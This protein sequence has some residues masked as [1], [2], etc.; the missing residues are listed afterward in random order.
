MSEG[1]E[2]R[3]AGEEAL[4]GEGTVLVLLHGRGADETDLLGLSRHLPATWTVVAP[5]APFSATPWGY[6]PGW[7]WYRY[8]GEDRPEPE[9]YEQSLRAVSE[10]IGALPVKYGFDADRLVLGGFSQGGTISL[11]FSLATAAGHLGVDAPRVRRVVNLSGFLADHPLVEA[12]P[13]TVAGTR[14]FWGHGTADPAIPFE[15]A[16]RGRAALVAA[17]ADVRAHDYPAGH[18]IEPQELNDL[19]AWVDSRP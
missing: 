4:E 7:A 3:I 17:G 11:G 1:L 8:L 2:Y 18:W 9:S 15:L 13:D 5:R 6:G 14:I 12:K 19:V 10:L 16:V